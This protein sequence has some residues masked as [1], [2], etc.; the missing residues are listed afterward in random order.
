MN[1]SA[2]TIALVREPSDALMRCELT[3]LDRVAIQVPLARTQHER[4][5]GALSE[6]GLKIEWLPPLPQHPDAV[7][8]EDMAVIL[9]EV[10]VITR[11]GAESRRGEAASV[12]EALRAYRPSRSIDAPG[13][14]DGGDVLLIGKTLFVGSSGRTNPEGFAMLENAVSEFGYRV[15]AVRVADCL[16]LKS[17]CSFIPPDM[18]VANPSNVAKDVF[19]GLRVIAV[20]PREPTAANTLTVGGITLVHASCP[21]TEEKL[22]RAGVKTRSIDVSELQKAEAGLTCMSLVVDAVRDL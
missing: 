16:H 18:V 11:S 5:V 22:R 2:S 17:A 6:L 13:C 3:H 20:D 7:F 1:T 14:L 15:R 19:G 12:A 10:A 4:Y 8:V 9:P 21:R